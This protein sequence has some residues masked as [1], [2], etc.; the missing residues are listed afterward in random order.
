MYLK[1]SK[2][3]HS[4]KT[5]CSILNS[6]FFM[7]HYSFGISEEGSTDGLDLGP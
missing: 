5:D 1:N 2:S 3:N 6:L 4:K 7:E